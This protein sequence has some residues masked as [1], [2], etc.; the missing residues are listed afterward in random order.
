[1]NC[2]TGTGNEEAKQHYRAMFVV[3]KEISERNF[4]SQILKTL[5]SVNIPDEVSRVIP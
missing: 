4:Q 2:Y 1:M 3:K 5:I